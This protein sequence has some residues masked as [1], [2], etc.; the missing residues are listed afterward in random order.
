MVAPLK[1]ASQ[2]RAMTFSAPTQIPDLAGA[3][4][5]S[6]V[7]HATGPLAVDLH[8]IG[9]FRRG[10]A[11]SLVLLG[12]SMVGHPCSGVSPA[13]EHSVSSFCQPLAARP[14]LDRPLAVAPQSRRALLSRP[15]IGQTDR[16]TA[17][18]RGRSPPRVR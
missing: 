15:R 7:G 9:V 4:A 14:G 13:G 16:P 10:A 2:S 1:H 6:I 17:A 8:G 11:G 18:S 12:W 5:N 3:G